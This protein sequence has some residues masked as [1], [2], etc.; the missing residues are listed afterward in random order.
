MIEKIVLDHLSATLTVPVKGETQKPDKGAY[1]VV[2]KTGSGELDML[3]D[4]LVA[5]KSYGATLYEAAGL[6]EQVKAAMKTLIEHDEVTDCVLNTDFP[7]EDPATGRYR[8][9]A[10]FNIN[11]Y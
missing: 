11:H 9:Q 8:Y 7:D 6:N 1:C 2:E 10:V 5:V 3:Y 4:S